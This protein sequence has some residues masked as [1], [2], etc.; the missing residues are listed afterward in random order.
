MLGPGGGRNSDEVETKPVR[1][2]FDVLRYGHL[3]VRF[4]LALETLQH[5][6]KR[7]ITACFVP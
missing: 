1:F 3:Q 4:R 7:E 2:F 5:V 6:I